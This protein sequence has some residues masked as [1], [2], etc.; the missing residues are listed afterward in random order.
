MDLLVRRFFFLE[1]NSFCQK[2]SPHLLTYINAA[3]YFE[4]IVICS[5]PQGKSREESAQYAHDFLELIKEVKRSN[6]EVHQFHDHLFYLLEST[7]SIKDQLPL[8][9]LSYCI[10]PKS[11]YVC[12]WP[13]S[14]LQLPDE[15]KD[16]LGL[17]QDDALH[18]GMSWGIV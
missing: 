18:S 4:D 13:I 10:Q 17:P 16:A 1:M 7:P 12:N 5:S 14:C 8:Q 6:A 15:K 2:K 9:G 11:L 3:C